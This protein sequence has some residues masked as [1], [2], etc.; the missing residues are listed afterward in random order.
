L[1]PQTY[2]E[3]TSNY[4]RTKYSTINTLQHGVSTAHNFFIKLP[5][6]C[7]TSETKLP[8]FGFEFY[9]ETQTTHNLQHILQNL[10]LLTTLLKVKISRHS[11]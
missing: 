7:W 5:E 2:D 11:N 10:K 8:F 4:K 3:L 1:L 9:T 6:F